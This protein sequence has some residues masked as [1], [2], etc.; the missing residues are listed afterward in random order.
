[1]FVL[2]ANLFGDGAFRIPGI[3]K[4]AG[5][6]G[7]LLSA[8]RGV[9]GYAGGAFV[10]WPLIIIYLVREAPKA[11]RF[12]W[13]TLWPVLLLIVFMG[14][15]TLLSDA[16]VAIE[17]RGGNF[18]TYALPAMVCMLHCTNRKGI[19]LV[20]AWIIG[21][22]V[23]FLAMLAI[24][25]RLQALLAGDIFAVSGMTGLQNGPD[26]LTLQ[27]DTITTASLFYFAALAGLSLSVELKQWW[28]RVAVWAISGI[29][30]WIGLMAGAR[31]PLLG[32]LAASVLLFGFSRAAIAKKWLIAAVCCL[33]L[34]GGL[35]LLPEVVPQSA[36]R[37]FGLL[38]H[39]IPALDRYGS[40][41]DSL[42]TEA[43]R[44]LFTRAG[45]APLSWFGRGVGAFGEDYGDPSMYAHNLFLEA[46]Y[47][48]G[49][50]GVVVIGWIF[51]SCLA[52][53]LKY[54]LNGSSV[55]CFCLAS[56]TF[57]FVSSQFSGTLLDN[58]TLLAFLVLGRMAIAVERRSRLEDGAPSKP[59]KRR[60]LVSGSCA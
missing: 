45:S 15:M 27:S 50:V 19:Q 12:R 48:T 47:E 4:G 13:A 36:N 60:T 31:G 22:A 44:S 2:V 38:G 9:L 28:G 59:H 34:A 39:A 20:R 40:T 35:T 18:F 57:Y 37:I 14:F 17:M 42:E 23:V 21:A 53:L 56:L 41:A 32:F 49:V 6:M 8:I 58:R 5:T 43:R 54:S 33:F 10:V 29:S 3:D 24:S 46:Y 7:L 11:V 55:V 52:Q 30:V 51:C 16:R 26:R 25:G 1:L